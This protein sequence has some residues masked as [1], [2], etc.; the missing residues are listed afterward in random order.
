MPK[1]ATGSLWVAERI[2]TMLRVTDEIKDRAGCLRS[3]GTYVRIVPI[4]PGEKPRIGPLASL[5]Y[6]RT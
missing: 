2:R 5:S 1:V 6:W 4:G 3:S